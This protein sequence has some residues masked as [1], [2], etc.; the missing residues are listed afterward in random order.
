MIKNKVLMKIFEAKRD[1]VTGEWRKL[2]NA[3][4]HALYSPPD[5]IRNIKS[6]RLRWA[7]HV[8]RMVRPICNTGTVD[9]LMCSCKERRKL[10]RLIGTFVLQ[11]PRSAGAMHFRVLFSLVLVFWSAS[12]SGF[13]GADDRY[14][15]NELKKMN[16]VNVVIKIL[17]KLD[18]EGYKETDCEM[19]RKAL[20][21]VDDI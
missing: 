16:P 8:A 6:R 9:V 13:G 10:N 18:E 2:H 5:I 17:D 20:E 4:L 21:V 11:D 19:S 12:V 14:I 1:E 7:E 15:K 3:E